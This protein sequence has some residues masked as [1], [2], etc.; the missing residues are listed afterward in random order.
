M[1][2]ENTTVYT[3][4]QVLRFQR[5]DARIFKA[6]PAGSH[7]IFALLFILL[8]CALAYSINAHRWLFTALFAIAIALLGRRYYFLYIAPARK[9]DDSSFKDLKHKCSFRDSGAKLDANGSEQEFYYD[10]LLC[11]YE[12][13]NKAQALIVDKSGFTQGNAEELAG[14]LKQKL[15]SRYYTTI[16]K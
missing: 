4:E 7:I 2:L 16:N 11:A 1:E 10:K 6:F 13:P 8:A 9:F 5:F 14:L 3:R 15:G 12:T